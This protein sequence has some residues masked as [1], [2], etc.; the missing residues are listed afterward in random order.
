MKT[1]PKPAPKIL[2]VQIREAKENPL[3]SEAQREAVRFLC[4]NQPVACAQCGKK[5]RTLWTMLCAFRS[6][7]L[8]SPEG[9]KRFTIDA[10]R[11]GQPFPPLAGVCGDHPLAPDWPEKKP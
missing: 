1:K 8:T 6:I 5:K 10:Q 2:F 11:D 7:D 3:F 4:Y 9:A